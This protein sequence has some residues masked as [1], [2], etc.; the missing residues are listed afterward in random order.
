[1]SHP[2]GYR[3]QLVVLALVIKHRTHPQLPTPSAK[4]IALS[5]NPQI[6]LDQLAGCYCRSTWTAHSNDDED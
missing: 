1:M 6:H 3:Q 2:R 4:K 5:A